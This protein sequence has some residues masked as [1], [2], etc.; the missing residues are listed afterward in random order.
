MM[1]RK[2][3]EQLADELAI[4]RKDI[5]RCADERTLEDRLFGFELCMNTVANALKRDNSHFDKMRF[6]SAVRTRSTAT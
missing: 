2:G 1:T 3:Y 4:E 6:I 5:L